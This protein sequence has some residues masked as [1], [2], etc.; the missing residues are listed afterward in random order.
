MRIEEATEATQQTLHKTYPD[1]NEPERD[2]KEPRR[3]A[4]SLSSSRAQEA[5]PQRYAGPFYAL[6]FRNFRLFFIG[7]LISVAGTWMQAVAQQWLVFSLTRSAAWLGIVSGA[8]ALPYVVFAMWGGQVADRYS[9]RAVL[10]WT[11]V[12][13]MVLAF[14]LAILATNRWVP[15]QAW[16]VAVL[17][18]LLGIVNA[19]NMPAQQ[20]FVTDIVDERDALSNA[21]ALNSLRFNLARFLGPWLA[22]G[23]LIRYGMAAC[24]TLNGLSFLAVITSLMMMRMPP[25]QRREHHV[26]IWEGFVFIRHHL[27]VF[28]V[29]ALIGLGSFF[30]WSVSTLFPI[31]AAHFHSGARGF[32][33]MMAANGVGAA[34]GGMTIATFGDRLS[35]RLLIYGGAGL[36][37]ISLLLLAAAPHYGIALAWLVLSGFSMIIFAISANTKVQ[38]DVPDALRGRVMA[39]YSLVFSALMPLGSLQI[40]FLADHWSA[41]NAV[42]LNAALLLLVTLFLLLWS[43][44]ERRAAYTDPGSDPIS[45]PT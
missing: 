13:A 25:F 38:E 21:I 19:F 20:A 17:A 14:V 30:G 36:Y 42:R 9:R 5:V 11:Q 15:V 6:S 1:V 31:F 10:I 26:S 27:S 43:R 16:H 33:A 39:V 7:Q 45:L 4:D 23:V 28:R 40:G 12:A 34:L 3:E 8:S 18:G 32:T 35:R 2:D 44:R 37:C 41:A 24:F 22:G 29:I